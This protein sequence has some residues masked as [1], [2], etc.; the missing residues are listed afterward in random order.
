MEQ[1]KFQQIKREYLKKVEFAKQ[2]AFHHERMAKRWEW[3]LIGCSAITTILAALSSV[4]RAFL[5][6]PMTLLFSTLVTII[7]GIM[8]SQKNQEK[9]FSYQKFRSD[10][11]NEYR[12]YLAGTGR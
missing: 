6:T 5:L 4:I 11:E 8:K 9:W 10:L 7:A 2:R 1:E 12:W 3:A